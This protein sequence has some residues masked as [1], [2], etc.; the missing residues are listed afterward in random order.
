MTFQL[1][2][3]VVLRGRAVGRVVAVTA[4]T[5]TVEELELRGGE[6]SVFDVPA[7][8]AIDVLRPVVAADEARELLRQLADVAA[9]EATSTGQRAIRYRRAL[10]DGDLPTQ[11]AVLATIYRHPS[12]EY[13]E[14]QH[15]ERLERAVFAELALALGR[16]RKALKAEVRALIL[17]QP[18]PRSLQLQD[19]SEE[20][21]RWDRLPTWEGHTGIGAFAVDS[22]LA[23]GE[24]QPDVTFP[25]EPGIWLAYSREYHGDCGELV[26]VHQRFFE[27]AEQ[28]IRNAVEGGRASAEGATMAI[29]DAA[30]ADDD[31]LVEEILYE[32]QGVVGQRCAVISL[33][34]DGACRVQV[35]R[36]HGRAV[37]VR[38]H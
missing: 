23:V 14:R 32:G 19:R 27:E 4:E 16:G 3:H 25:A 35:S 36:K 5:I 12:P 9:D 30:V 7:S 18:P 22:E 17:G 2:Q 29:F 38:V 11:I 21:A 1:G 13:P 6:E 33:G 20:L 37:L 24:A 28:L 26:V 15:L 34:G 8:N 10:K 31:E